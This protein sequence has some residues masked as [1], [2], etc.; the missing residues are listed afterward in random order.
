[1]D[2]KKPTAVMIGNESKGLS[3]E[4]TALADRAILIPM[5]GQVESLNAAM[6]AAV[7]SFEAARQRRTIT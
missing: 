3:R 1:V 2:Y 4:I 7:I 5:C 6:A